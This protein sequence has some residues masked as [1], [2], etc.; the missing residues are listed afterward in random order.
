MDPAAYWTKSAPPS[1]TGNE[2]SE[3]VGAGWSTGSG[4]IF[5][6]ALLVCDII[7]GEIDQREMFL[8]IPVVLSC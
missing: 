1:P 8:V 3:R 4:R 5:E 2:R 6:M 7:R